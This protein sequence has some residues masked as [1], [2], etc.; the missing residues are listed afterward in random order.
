MRSQELVSTF[1]RHHAVD[2]RGLPVEERDAI[3][4]ACD[5][6]NAISEGYAQ[7]PSTLLDH[8]PAVGVLWQLYERCTDQVH[9]ALVAMATSCAASSEVLARVALEAAIT[10]RY[11]LGDRNPRLAAYFQNYIVQTDRQVN[12]WLKA[13]EQLKGIEKT[14]NIDACQY[15][16]QYLSVIR[17]FVDTI[18]SRLVASGIVPSWP[19]IASRFEALGEAVRYRTFY[20]RLCTETHF[21][22]EETLRYVIASP[23]SA[24]HFEKMA[25][26][27]AMF[28]RFCLLEAVRSYAEAGKEF[29]A[30]YNMVAAIEAC[31]SAEK[32]MKR[33]ALNLSRYIG[34][35]EL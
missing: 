23:T 24:E 34:A 29:A 2:I 16:K 33:H 28:S 18:N 9:G 12:Q 25:T 30:S 3:Y 21:D 31:A 19:N 11:I 17:Q 13:A 1:A 27:T 10:I 8:D 20:G 22:A 15:R 32:L 7:L 14:I 4:C 26:E 6:Q 5:C 35:K